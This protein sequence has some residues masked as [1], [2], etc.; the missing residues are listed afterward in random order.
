MDGKYA[1]DGMRLMKLIRRVIADDKEIESMCRDIAEPDGLCVV[2]DVGVE[3]GIL[4]EGDGD[5]ANPE[6][7]DATGVTPEFTDKDQKFLT[8]LRISLL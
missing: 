3:I 5:S 4:S 7:A 2:I 6:V 8:A 1:E